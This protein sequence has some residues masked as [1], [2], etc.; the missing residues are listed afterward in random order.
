MILPPVFPSR[1][2]LAVSD[3]HFDRGSDGPF[4]VENWMA[5]GRMLGMALDLDSGTL[6]VSVDGG[7]WVVAFPSATHTSSC[8]PSADAGGA[9]FPVV[10]GNSGV[11]VQCNWGASRP[12][13][14]DP[15]SRDYIAL[16]L[17]QK[18]PLAGLALHSLFS[19][20]EWF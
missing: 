10:C 4:V 18:V 17:A 2:R 13:K 12:M 6:R 9:L 16:G 14:H 1:Q 20:A 3:I 15:P 8:R 5:E 11:V 7:E 19:L